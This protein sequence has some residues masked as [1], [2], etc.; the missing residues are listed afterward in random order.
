MAQ[1]ISRSITY[2]LL[3]LDLLLCPS[4][5]PRP[6]AQHP[7]GQHGGLESL[8]SL[9]RYPNQGGLSLTRETRHRPLGK[10]ITNEIHR[11]GGSPTKCS[12]LGVY[13][14]RSPGLMGGHT[15]IPP[16]FQTKWMGFALFKTTE[17]QTREPRKVKP[18]KDVF[19]ASTSSQDRAIRA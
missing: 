8:A 1:K 3:L 7:D 18:S 10:S 6:A 9:G 12:V 5:L 15:H 17:S 11:L 13:S 2:R 19:A 4:I 16:P 14:G